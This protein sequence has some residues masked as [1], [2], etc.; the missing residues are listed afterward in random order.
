MA[1]DASAAGGASSIAPTVTAPQAA[2]ADDSDP[3]FDDLDD[4]LDQFSANAPAPESIQATKDVSEPVPTSSGPGRPQEEALNL[5]TQ[6]LPD[7]PKPGESEEEFIGRLSSEMSKLL[8]NIPD[9]AGEGQ[10]PEDLVKMGKDLEEFT[11]K[12]EEQGVKPEDLLKAILGEE[13]GNKIVNAAYA[14]RDRKDSENEQSR[15]STSTSNT[16][17]A[18]AGKTTTSFEDTIRQTMSRLNESDTQAKNAS[19]Q[20]TSKS[21]EDMLADLLKS[22]DTGGGE[23]DDDGV[24]KMFLEMMHQLTHKSMLY[25]PMKDLNDRYPD[26]LKSHKPPKM[27]EEDYDRYEKQ[28]VIVR[29]IVHKYQEPGFKDEDEQCRDFIWNKMQDMQNLGAPPEELV[30]NPFPGMNFGSLPGL[31]GGG[32]SGGGGEDEGCPTQ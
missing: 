16:K 23:G 21:E 5:S 15:P 13:E 18:A 22:L 11:Q 29:D 30:Q 7:G 4:V 3:D 9:D 1:D 12:M 24:S 27:K 17:Q 28:S 8:G 25:E 32:G 26:W 20:S 2:V 10:T 31:G 19:Q 14:E 6:P